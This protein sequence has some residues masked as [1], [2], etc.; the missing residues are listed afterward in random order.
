MKCIAFIILFLV[1]ILLYGLY[2]TLQGTKPVLYLC[3]TLT[4]ETCKIFD[5]RTSQDVFLLRTHKWDPSIEELW[6]QMQHDLGDKQVYV[7]YDITGNRQIPSI[8]KNLIT[9]TDRECLELQSSYNGSWYTLESPLVLAYQK[10]KKMKKWKY[11]WLIEYDVRCTGNWSYVLQRAIDHHPTADF[12]AYNVESY[13]SSPCWPGW[14]FLYKHPDQW[15]G[16]N[17]YAPLPFFRWKSFLPISRYSRQALD[18]FERTCGEYTDYCEIYL[19]TQCK[20]N[21]LTVDNLHQDCIGHMYRA[22]KSYTAD[23]W[24]I[25]CNVPG[26]LYHP[27]K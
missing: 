14:S 27:I 7:L 18:L 22:D 11:L 10:L 25:L 9:V 21:G 8:I 23:N 3:P 13:W 5:Y 26:K 16:I 4:K 6:K 17:A 15:Y 19:P 20:I 24:S 1:I 12:V 2:I